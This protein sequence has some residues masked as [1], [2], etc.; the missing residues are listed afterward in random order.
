M[1]RS[2]TTLVML[3]VLASAAFAQTP[4][5][6]P[7]MAPDTPPVWGP[8]QGPGGP[9]QLQMLRQQVEERFGRM[10]QN[11]LQLT[12]PQ[13]QQLRTAMRASED[14]RREIARRQQ[15]LQ[16]GIGDQMQPGRAANQDSVSRMLDRMAHTRTEMAQSD[17][18]FMRELGFLT[19]VQ[20]ARLAM[21][22]RRFEERM[23]QIRQDR[24]RQG[25]GGGMR[26]P[27]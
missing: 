1:K 6:N 18:Q 27:G 19:P 10:V 23:Q 5:P 16:R 17:E 3:A 7:P 15:D 24:M 25:F 20:R 21:M 11:Q 8:G 26:R 14:R 13:M 12:E 4:P 22:L 2:G 9:A